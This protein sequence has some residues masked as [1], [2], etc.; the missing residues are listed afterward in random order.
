MWKRVQNM[1]WTGSVYKDRNTILGTILT[2]DNAP[3][4]GGTGDLTAK[5]QL[6]G[7]D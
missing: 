1:F 4:R 5:R 3:E 2:P 6:F 7:S